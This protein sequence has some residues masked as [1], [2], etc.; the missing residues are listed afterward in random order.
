MNAGTSSGEKF[1]RISHGLPGSR[2]NWHGSCF[3]LSLSL[4]LISSSLLITVLRDEPA[5]R[6]ALPPSLYLS[7][8]KNAGVLRMENGR[9]FCSGFDKNIP[10]GS[11][12]KRK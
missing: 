4:S 5:Q 3:S 7:R 11:V 10:G 6:A 8:V 2:L 9:F 1:V 12:G